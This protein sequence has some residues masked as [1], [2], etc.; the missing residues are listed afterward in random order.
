MRVKELSKHFTVS[1]RLWTRFRF[2]FRNY[3]NAMRKI[4]YYE[5]EKTQ[6]NKKNRKE[7]LFNTT[8]AAT[9]F[10]FTTRGKRERKK[11]A[12]SWPAAIKKGSA[13]PEQERDT[14]TDLRRGK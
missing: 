10:L 13:A 1:I 4:T 7:E 12:L 14:F 3:I 2:Q 5:G 11:A 6:C 8:K 9:V